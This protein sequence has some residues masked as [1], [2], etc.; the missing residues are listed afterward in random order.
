MIV[1]LVFEPFGVLSVIGMQLT[2]QSS[3]LLSFKIPAKVFNPNSI[4]NGFKLA[5]SFDIG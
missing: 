4:K 2:V 3:Q 1:A 5:Q